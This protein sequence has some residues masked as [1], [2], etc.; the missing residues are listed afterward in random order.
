MRGSWRTPLWLSLVARHACA[1]PV[2]DGSKLLRRGDGDLCYLNNQ[3]IAKV[4][5]RLYFMG[6]DYHFDGDA[7]GETFSSDSL[8]YF[9]LSGNTD[10][11]ADTII[12]SSSLNK[13][14]VPFDTTP[15]LENQTHAQG[16]AL[17]STLDSFY[18]FAGLG[19][20]S[21]TENNV[22]AAY[23]RTSSQWSSHTVSGGNYNK[24]NRLF[25]GTAS[26][27]STGLSFFSGGGSSGTNKPGQPTGMLR[28]DASNPNAL[29]WRNET[30]ESSSGV[31]VPA[32]VG[33]NMVYVPMGEQGVIL[34]WGGYN[35]TEVNNQTGLPAFSY[36]LIDNRRIYVYDI[37][38]ASW[39]IVY[40]QGDDIPGRRSE[41]CAVVSAAPDYSSF[42]IAMYGGW[43]LYD[44]EAYSE[45]WVLSVPSFRWIKMESANYTGSNTEA[46]QGNKQGRHQH[47]CAV[48][49]DAQ[50]IVLGGLINK[51]GTDQAHV[52]DSQL[53]PL[54]IL[55]LATM[56]WQK[57]FDASAEYSVPEDVY[58]VIGGD[59]SG[60]A[61]LTQPDGGFNDTSVAR[62]FATTVARAS[63]ST[64]SATSTATGSSSSSSSDDSAKHTAIVGGIVGGVV[65][66][67]AGL[68]A[69]VTIA[70]L[71]LR[72]KRKNREGAMMAVPQHDGTTPLAGSPGQHQGGSGEYAMGAYGGGAEHYGGQTD[73]EKR[74]A[75][76]DPGTGLMEADGAHERPVV[77]EVEGR[78][79]AEM[80]GDGPKD[81]Y[82]RS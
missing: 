21:T 49:N 17:F 3:K 35:G 33:G 52:C 46:L 27:P 19:E 1:F 58:A 77:R 32:R 73:A 74:P 67:V 11:Q 24:L 41:T 55:N 65:G 72:H 30:A 50:M 69:I 70:W 43:N 42:N 9:D 40:A 71:V 79:V 82:R 59:G 53:P 7:D 45:T 62:I 18:V 31:S 57:S 47:H 37:A 26:I 68:A 6:G 81:V 23:N 22:L 64:A 39:N 36:Q 28:F 44:G 66:G 63:D 56:T 2:E 51:N 25:P 38:S 54:R 14:S 75:E 13:I 12:S 10:I 78:M 16:G 4:D 29:T 8:Y 15:T 80:E 5:D 48:H 61:K 60:N 20:G 76:L 34:L